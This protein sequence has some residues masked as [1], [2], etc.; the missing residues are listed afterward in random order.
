MGDPLE[1][2]SLERSLDRLA[3]D[4]LPPGAGL[5]ILHDEVFVVDSGEMKL[6]ILSV[7]RPLPHQTGVA[8]RSIGRYQIDAAHPVMDQVMV[9]Q[10]ADRVGRRLAVDLD[11][12]DAVFLRQKRRLGRR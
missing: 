7:Q 11:S 6:Q 9:G 8:K 2:R 12:Q 4:L 5:L 3:G 10:G 1:L